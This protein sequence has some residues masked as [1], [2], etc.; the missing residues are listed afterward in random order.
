MKSISKVLLFAVALLVCAGS[1]AQQPGGKPFSVQQAVEYAIKN[2]PSVQAAQLD[3]QSAKARIGEIRSIGLPQ[4]DAQVDIGN[5]LAIQTV[6]LPGIFAGD[7]TAGAIFP[8]QF[9]TKYNG[10]AGINAS[11]L[12]FD[13]SYLIG[14]R[15]AQTYAE[16]SVKQVKQT[17]IEVADAVTRAY[18]TVLITEA[19]MPLLDVNITRLDT[20]LRQTQAMNREGFVETIDVQRLE[21]ARNNLQTEKDKL[22][23]LQALSYQLLKF[24]MGMPQTEVI[25]LTDKLN[26]I[27]VNTLA[28]AGETPDYSQRIEY[29]VLQTQQRLAEL[30]L[31]NKRAG[32]YPRLFLAGRLGYNTGTD[33]LGELTKFNQNWYKFSFVGVSLQ[34][35]LFDG[36]RK[37]YQTKQAKLTIEKTR[38]GFKELENAIDL[39][40]AQARISLQ[41]AREQL[42]TQRRNRELAQ[43]VA[44][45]TQIKYREGVGS[46]LE[47]V[48]AEAELRTADINYFGALYDLIIAQVDLQ[49]ATGT[50]Y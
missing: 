26:D 23:R 18:Y 39:Q 4:V 12:L 13:G 11:Q 21:V 34:V 2:R 49:K 33:D 3:V 31:R 50:L 16:L 28:T 41:N 10:N 40:L 22:M 8:A 1:W 7:T 5:N 44:R 47:V 14:L 15:A 35:P 46:N 36:L 32:Y 42:Q 45:V 38:Y 25:T 29:S 24:N 27:E 48:T 19:R 6:F 9:G 17:E 30:D 37:H 43:E 20:I